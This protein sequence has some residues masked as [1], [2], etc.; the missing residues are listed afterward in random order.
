MVNAVRRSGSEANHRRL[1]NP[2]N[3]VMGT[4]VEVLLVGSCTVRFCVAFLLGVRVAFLLELSELA[5]PIVV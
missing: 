4:C 2:R 1:D 3:G 5:K